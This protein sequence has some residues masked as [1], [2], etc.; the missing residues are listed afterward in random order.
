MISADDLEQLVQALRDN[1]SSVR[2]EAEDRLR[3]SIFDKSEI[4]VWW[5]L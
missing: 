1:D 4:V 5:I 3:K 2:S